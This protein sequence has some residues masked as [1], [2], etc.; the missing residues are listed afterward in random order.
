MR[1]GALTPSGTPRRP[2]TPFCDQHA[3]M[4]RTE[5]LTLVLD[6][7]SCHWGFTCTDYTQG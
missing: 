6:V 5:A 7:R 1:A 4:K 3:N 2:Q